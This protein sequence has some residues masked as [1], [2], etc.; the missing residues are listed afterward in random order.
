MWTRMHEWMPS[1]MD[2]FSDGSR[3]PSRQS[4]KKYCFRNDLSRVVISLKSFV[5]LPRYEN[6]FENNYLRGQIFKKKDYDELFSRLDDL[7]FMVIKDKD[8]VDD[9]KIHGIRGLVTS[10]MVESALANFHFPYF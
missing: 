5:I 9:F 7:C 6:G 4:I 8:F 1:K 10:R 2:V 3:L